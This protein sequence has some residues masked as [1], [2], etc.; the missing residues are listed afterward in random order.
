MLTTGNGMPTFNIFMYFAY[1]GSFLSEGLPLLAASDISSLLCPPLF[2]NILDRF[3]LTSL[4]LLSISS[5][6]GFALFLIIAINA[7]LGSEF[8]CVD[9]DSSL[10]RGELLGGGDSLVKFSRSASKFDLRS[11]NGEANSVFGL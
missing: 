4:L 6:S 5:G 8:G 9:S 7:A 2:A 3:C 1:F 10:R 11:F